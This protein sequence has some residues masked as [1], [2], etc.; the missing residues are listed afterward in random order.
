MTRAARGVDEAVAPAAREMHDAF[1]AA[2]LPLR[3][4]G[5]EPLRAARAQVLEQL[6]DYVL[7]RLDRIDAP[8]LVVVGG[9]TGVGKS[10]LVNSLIGHPVT[11]PGLLRPTT[12]SPVLVHHPDDAGWFGAD[13]ILGGLERVVAES[14]AQDA[15]QLVATASA[16]RG[17][18]ILD[19]PD[20]D[21][22]DEGNRALSLRLL[23]AAD[24]WLFVTSAARYSD[25]LPWEQLE[26]AV[27]R[28]TP[29]AVVMSRVP[30]EDHATV[31][32]H[33]HLMLATRGVP[34][35]QVL[36]VAAGD[37]GEHG[38]L[39]AAEVAHVRAFLDGIAASPVRRT[40]LVAQAVTGALRPAAASAVA[41]ASALEDQVGAVGELLA[42]ADATYDEA[43]RELVAAVG[44]G[45]LLRGDLL[46]RWQDLL[47]TDDVDL[48]VTGAGGLRD[49]LTSLSAEQEQQVDRLGLALD[50]ALES[51]VVDHAERAAIATSRAL[52]D[53]AHG[54]ALLDWSAED[55]SRPS[56]SIGRRVRAET[57][58][59]REELVAEVGATADPAASPADRARLSA[60]AL[61]LAV[62]AASS[63]PAGATGATG[64]LRQ[65]AARGMRGLVERL[66][67]Q[68]RARYLE[69]VLGWGLEPDAPARLRRAARRVAHLVAEEE[70]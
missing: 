53:T 60:L 50:M 52:R 2:P 8:P 48:S 65:G 51:L 14:D 15:I 56:R 66:I 67:D 19:A 13:R 7:P 29:V 31:S 59:W 44:D 5:T 40:A 62:S 20:F 16:P 57:R 24:L 32:A 9:P 12:R 70:R 22:I 41:A 38:V 33:L 18:A 37:V 6:E 3:L 11:R 64:G 49:R 55:L 54:D 25:L 27:S 34:A 21:S 68:E 17:L 46:A 61:A 63:G 1:R 39:P 30:A 47:G 36:F 45:S 69:P 42:L 58:R 43:K 26:L 23:A 4:P 10:T 28:N 35:E